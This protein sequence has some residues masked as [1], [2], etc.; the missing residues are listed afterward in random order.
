MDCRVRF[1]MLDPNAE[2]SDLF[3]AFDSGLW[4]LEVCCLRVGFATAA[5]ET[6]QRLEPFGALYMPAG[7]DN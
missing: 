7:D 5:R 1:E 6:D 3:C 4:G 2:A